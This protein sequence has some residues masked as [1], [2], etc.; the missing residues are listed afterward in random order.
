METAYNYSLKLFSY[1]SPK[2]MEYQAFKWII[3]TRLGKFLF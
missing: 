2:I 3:N 1:C